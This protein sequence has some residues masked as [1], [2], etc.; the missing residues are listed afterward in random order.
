MATL[1][2]IPTAPGPRPSHPR[3]CVGAACSQYG[4]RYVQV[5]GFPAVPTPAAFTALFI[6]SALANTGTFVTDNSLINAIQHCH[7]YA[8][9]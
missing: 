9:T 7:V 8:G 6:H 3:V 1:S 5:S 2:S 4:F